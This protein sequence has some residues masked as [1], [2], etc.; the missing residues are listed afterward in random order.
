MEKEIIKL[1]E[2]DLKELNIKIHSVK[3]FSKHQTNFLEI[4]LKKEGIF[5]VDDIVDATN[6][7]EPIL[8]EAD[9]ISD[10]YVLDISSKGID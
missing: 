9:L 5:K 7:I 6:V 3:Y 2:D 10:E 1:I 4:L 8:D